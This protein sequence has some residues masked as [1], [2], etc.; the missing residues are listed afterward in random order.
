MVLLLVVRVD[1]GAATD[2]A[3]SAHGGAFT[4]LAVVKG[5]PAEQLMLCLRCCRCPQ[6]LVRL[7]L[8]CSKADGSMLASVSPRFQPSAEAHDE[9]IRGPFCGPASADAKRSQI[10]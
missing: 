5:L 10:D 3:G 4:A 9:G 6:L 7:L 1:G 2:I 8:F